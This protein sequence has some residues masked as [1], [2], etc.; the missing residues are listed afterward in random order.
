M[1]APR[2]LHNYLLTSLVPSPK[3]SAASIGNVTATCSTAKKSAKAQVELPLYFVA[4]NA[5]L[6]MLRQ[7]FM[8][9]DEKDQNLVTHLTKVPFH[10]VDHS[11]PL[12]FIDI[13]KQLSLANLRKITGTFKKGRANTRADAFALINDR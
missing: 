3:M 4:E 8:K 10:E 7:C 9:F 2:F 11:D 6:S 5:D 13:S 1:T 12:Q